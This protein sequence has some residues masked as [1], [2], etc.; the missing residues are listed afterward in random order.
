[1]SMRL[2]DEK[3]LHTR[4]PERTLGSE[5]DDARQG[6]DPGVSSGKTAGRWSQ[7]DLVYLTRPSGAVRGARIGCAVTRS[8]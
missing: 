6:S 7:E 4:L 2:N 1:M 8:A 3:P 5:C